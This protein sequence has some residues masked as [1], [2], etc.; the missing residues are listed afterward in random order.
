MELISQCF[1]P[2]KLLNGHQK[3]TVKP[4]CLSRTS[5]SERFSHFG[6]Y[7]TWFV[8]I[9]MNVLTMQRTLI[10]FEN[11]KLYSCKRV[12][13]IIIGIRSNMVAI[14]YRLVIRIKKITHLHTINIKFSYTHSNLRRNSAHLH[15]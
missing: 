14:R 10:D 3:N 2:Q 8:R 1:D 11:G 12:F 6:R 5:T 13:D 15:L 9:N 7:R 4:L